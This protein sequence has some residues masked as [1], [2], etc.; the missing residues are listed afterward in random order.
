MPIANISML[1]SDTT[2][3]TCLDYVERWIQGPNKD[4][5]VNT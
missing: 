1:S 2:Q 4:E 5:V 3:L